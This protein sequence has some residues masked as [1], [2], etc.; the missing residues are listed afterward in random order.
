MY[1]MIVTH[2]MH[3]NSITYALKPGDIIQYEKMRVQ[4]A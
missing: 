1:T 4:R 2:S 3:Y